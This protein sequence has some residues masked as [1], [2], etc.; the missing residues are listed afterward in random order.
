MGR[1]VYLGVEPN[2]GGFCPPKWMVKISWF[3]PYEQIRMI[4]GVR[5]PHYFRK[6]HPYYLRK[7]LIFMGVHGSVNIP[8][9]S[10]GNP[11]GLILLVVDFC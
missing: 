11:L 1:T 4:L 9:S 10:H 8:I 5:F 7:W 3:Q 6:K 2:I